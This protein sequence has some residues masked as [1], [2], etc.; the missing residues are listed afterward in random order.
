MKELFSIQKISG[1]ILSCGAAV[2]LAGCVEHQKTAAYRY[3]EPLSSP[4]QQFSG[5]PPAVQKTV[6][7]Q[8]GGADIYNVV[9]IERFD[10]PVYKIIFQDPKLFPPLYVNADGSVLYPDLNHVAVGAGKEDIGAMSGGAASGLKLS[11]LPQKVVSL[12]QEKAPTA[13]VAFIHQVTFNGRVFYEVS[14]KDPLRNPDLVISE[15]GSLVKKIW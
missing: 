11:D 10:Q 6:R 2:Y 12:I 14:F 5:L 4:G 7:A 8:V 9:K 1:A 13:E 3:H 15:E